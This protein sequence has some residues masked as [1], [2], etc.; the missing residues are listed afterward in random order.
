LCQFISLITLIR[1]VAR[2]AGRHQALQIAA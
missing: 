1:K 2:G